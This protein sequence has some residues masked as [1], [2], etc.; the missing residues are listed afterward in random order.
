VTTFQ[1][2]SEKK[3]ILQEA[4]RTYLKEEEMND[5]DLYNQIIESR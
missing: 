3:R 4:R 1:R 2:L 5:K